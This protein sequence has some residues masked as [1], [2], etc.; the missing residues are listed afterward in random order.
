MI[1]DKLNISVIG[2]GS[3]TFNVLYGLKNIETTHEKNLAAIIAMTDSGGTTGHIR[4]KYGVLPPGDIRRGI[5]ALAEDTG[6]VR[7]LFEYKFEG[8]KGVIGGNKIGNILLT[9]LNEISGGFEAGLDEACKM[10]RVKGK[11][12]P[13]TLEDVHL[14]V[15][16]EDG[17]E[18]IGEKN[19]DVS[20]KNNGEKTHNVNQNI[21]DAFLVGGEG[22]I[23]PKAY[24]TILASDLVIIGPGDF[25]TSIVPNLLSPGMREA[26]E[27]TDATIV[28]VCNIMS[29]LGETT[30]YELPDFIENI[31]KYAG[32]VIDYVLVNNGH[33]SDELVE[34][35]K[36]EGKKPVKK[37]EEQDFS[38]KHYKVIERDFLDESDYVRHNPSKLAKV[39][40]DIVEGWIK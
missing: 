33:I 10:F 15:R 22:N 28:Y 40:V 9:A 3:G 14:G 6:F 32:N 37:K 35:Y 8:E 7:K 5:A 39:L 12:I 25:Y 21:V 17:T 34:K 16:F 38:G 2:G 36:K 26:L 13:V 24:D 31:E 1:K 27:K 30:H 19:I 23:N 29:D 11:V 4:D 20:E 18:V